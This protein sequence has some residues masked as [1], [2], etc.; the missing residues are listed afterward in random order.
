MFG[1]DTTARFASAAFAVLLTVA[2]FAYA[3]VPASPG[4]VA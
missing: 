3:I 2:S 4:L 1:P